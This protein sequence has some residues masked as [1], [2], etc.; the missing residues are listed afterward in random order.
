MALA[1]LL[2]ARPKWV[3]MDEALSAYRDGRRREI[4]ATLGRELPGT[5]FLGT[6]LPDQENGFWTR[7]VRLSKT[8][9]QPRRPVLPATGAPDGLGDA[10]MTARA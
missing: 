9:S 1:R 4:L 10:A 7:T 8:P 5:G 6:G 3:I 2:L